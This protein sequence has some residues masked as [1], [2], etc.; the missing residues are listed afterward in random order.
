[1]SIVLGNYSLCVAVLMAVVSLLVSLA[2]VRLG[3]PGIRRTARWGILSLAILLTVSCIVLLQS[4]ISS[5][6]RLAYVAHYTE[7][8]LPM[9]YKVA[10]FW[11]GQEGSL[12]LWAWLLAIMSVIFVI[13]H[14][15]QEGSEY[16]VAT[17]TLAAVL[18]FFAA[19]LLFAANPFDQS[20]SPVAD[21]HGLNPLLQNVGMIAHPPTLFIGYA[22]F[23]IPFALLVGVLITGRLG[24]DWIARARPWAL[25][26]WLFLGVGIA[27]G[28]QWAYVELGWGGYW[29]WDP[30]ENASLLPWLTGT[31][32]LHSN[33]GQRQRGMFKR[34]NAVLV[35]GTFLLCIFGT[36]ITRSGVVQSVHGF[37][38]SLVGTFFLVFLFL[39][40]LLS[41]GFILW[42]WPALKP[43]KRIE[44]WIS[45]EGGFL[46]ANI[47]LVTMMILTL[48]GTML[49]VISRVLAGQSVSANQASY[50]RMVL[51]LALV[52]FATMGVAPLLP[53]GRIVGK[54]M[55]RSSAFPLIVA[56]FAVVVLLVLKIRNP[57]ALASAAVAAMVLAG[58]LLDLFRGLVACRQNTQ[59]NWLRVPVRL[60]TAGYRRYAAQA[61][62]AGMAMV[63]I[64]IAGS[65]LYNTN[66]TLQLSPGQSAAV[67]RYHLRLDSIDETRGE[68]YSAVEA[69]VTMTD[70]AGAAQELRPQR[71]FY[72]KAEQPSSEVALRSNWREDLYVTLA[73]W[74]DGGQITALQVIVNPL[75][76]WIWAGAVVMTL[77]GLVC[78]LPRLRSRS[79][80]VSTPE[81]AI[82]KPAP[83]MR[84]AMG[85]TR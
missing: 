50:N 52:L 80:A 68:N 12:L 17:G 18:G 77:G 74:Q 25:V 54:K 61:V 55:L 38:E 7:R 46:T 57:W 60:I 64:G 82:Q 9:G 2:A 4:L 43:E 10:A 73:G 59:E 81:P 78:L 30:V 28:A 5:D 49:P 53:Y 34:W 8:A 48:L 47:L 31:A 70:P 35:A 40:T 69:R 13:R 22:G 71:R 27:L 44:G 36:Y 24:T 72:D 32:L 63:V 75:V 1:M 79:Q 84:V 58:V 83:T 65:S 20:P 16:A 15:K 6:F 76:L 41:I 85:V 39:T 42:R 62:H 67:G 21:G 51:P 26:S 19:L 56:I 11:A 66:Q 23:T 33:I 3:S 45:R 14:R 29:A 37:G